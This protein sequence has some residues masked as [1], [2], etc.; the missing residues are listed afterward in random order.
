MYVYIAKS[1]AFVYLFMRICLIYIEICARKEEK[2]HNKN[3]TIYYS[4]M[5]VLGQTIF[6]RIHM[7]FL[8]FRHLSKDLNEE[9]NTE[10]RGTCR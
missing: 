6:D 3:N 2:K 10:D 4:S 8:E 9:K 1:S 7:G 5:D